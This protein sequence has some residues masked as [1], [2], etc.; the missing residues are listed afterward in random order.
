MSTD[1]RRP[2]GDDGA[3]EDSRDV[4]H[5][6]GVDDGTG[7]RDGSS[8]G[9]GDAS[10]RDAW[11]RWTLPSLAVAGGLSALEVLRSRVQKKKLYAP[12]EFPEEWTPPARLPLEEVAVEAEGA[13]LYAWWIEHR[14][15]TAAVVYCH[16]STGNVTDRLEIVRVLRRLRLHVLAFDYRG[17]GRSTGSPTEKGLYRD[18]RAALDHVHR[19]RGVPW[20]RVLLFGQSLGGAVAIEGARS[21]PVAGLVV[22]STFTDLRDMARHSHPGTLLPWITRNEFRSIDKIADLRME[23]LFLHGGDDDRV[24]VAMGRELFEAAV[25][26]KAWMEIPGAGHHDVHRPRPLR[27]LLALRRFTKRA[28]GG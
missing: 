23:K 17:Y 25:E 10:P 2:P 22:Q 15:A 28:L 12:R 26:P 4:D 6:G 14:R 8:G 9:G 24:P 7:G 13:R 11:M 27:Y 5:K 21:R 16:G 19:E 3:M 1:E 20:D 18:V